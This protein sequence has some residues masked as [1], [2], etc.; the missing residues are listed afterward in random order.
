MCNLSELQTI[1]TKSFSMEIWEHCTHFS[2]LDRWRYSSKL[3]ITG[4]AAKSSQ[5]VKYGKDILDKEKMSADL[6]G[7]YQHHLLR[8]NIGSKRITSKILNSIYG[9]KELR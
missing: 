2:Y 3:K 4:D 9:F 6:C 7:R 5:I 8:I 1:K